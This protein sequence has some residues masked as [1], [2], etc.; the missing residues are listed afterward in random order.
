MAF[1][2]TYI[3]NEGSNLFSSLADN[4]TSIIWTTAKVSNYNLDSETPSYMRALMSIIDVNNTYS[5]TGSGPVTSA[6]N[7]DGNLTTTVSCQINNST[8]TNG[9]QAYL[10]GIWAKT[11]VD[12]T[13]KLVIVARHGGSSSEDVSYI[14]SQ[15]T[16]GLYTLS[17]SFALRIN[18]WAND[19]GLN[20]TLITDYYATSVELQNEI[21]A[22]SSL[23]ERAV[24]AHSVA[25]PSSGDIQTILGNKTFSSD[26]IIGSRL[27]FGNDSGPYLKAYANGIDS[28]GS[29]HPY[30][31]NI[32]TLGTSSYK[33]S[34][35]YATTFTGTTFTGNS[36][37]A[38]TAQGLSNTATLVYNATYGWVSSTSLS[39]SSDYG[40]NLGYYNSNGSYR[41]NYIYGRFLGNSSSYFTNAFI[42]TIYGTTFTGNSATASKV[43]ILGYS[44]SASKPLVFTESINNSTSSSVSKQLYTDAGNSLYYNPS[45]NTLT[46]P[47]FSGSL[48]GNATS[49]TNLTYSTTKLLSATSASQVTANT[50]IIPGINSAWG[51]GSSSYHWV[52]AYIDNLYIGSKSI[53]QYTAERL[54]NSN[55]YYRGQNNIQKH[56][57]YV[58]TW[59]IFIVTSVTFTYGYFG[60]NSNWSEDQSYISICRGT[61]TCFYSI[62]NSKYTAVNHGNGIL[63]VRIS[64]MTSNC[65]TYN[66]GNTKACYMFLNDF[67]WSDTGSNPGYITNG[68]PHTKTFNGT[69]LCIYTG[70]AEL[71]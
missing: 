18:D 40:A 9:G 7:S 61:S 59:G 65:N 54:T 63:Q 48:S 29:I 17:I 21:D 26:I 13:E 44:T 67:R 20:A 41:W 34:N 12:S 45:T 53:N 24:T 49:A 69:F 37:T 19:P 68:S 27:Y 62:N 30:M 38:T 56:Y 57:S 23:G 46:C 22:R 60:S 15:A 71:E 64:S 14:S 11:N 25:D 58:N 3:T 33:W 36:A 28:H 70:S 39:P 16:S 32:Y 47:T 6:I 66:S 35:V 31:A 2:D 4:S 43:G 42:T 5:Y 10:L 52:H 50:N 55:Y 8:Y 1:H 51:L